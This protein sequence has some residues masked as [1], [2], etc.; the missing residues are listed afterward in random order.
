MLLLL[1]GSYDSF[2]RCGDGGG[3]DNGPW[4][5]AGSYGGSPGPFRGSKGSTWEGGLRVPGIFRW[6]GTVESAS[7]EDSPISQLDIFNTIAQLAGL[8]VQRHPDEAMDSFSFA[9][10]LNSSFPEDIPRT[11]VYYFFQS[12]LLAIRSVCI[13]YRTCTHQE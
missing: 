4:T 12:H 7:R 3:S 5:E 10:L 9:H 1:T 2:S 11:A 8:A 13:L 6:P